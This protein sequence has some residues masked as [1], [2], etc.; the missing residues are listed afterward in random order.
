MVI[1]LKSV[2]VPLDYATIMLDVA[3]FFGKLDKVFAT[4]GDFFYPLG[5]VGTWGHYA[6]GSVV[7]VEP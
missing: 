5:D 7:L 4:I 2:A 3:A 1:K 6:F